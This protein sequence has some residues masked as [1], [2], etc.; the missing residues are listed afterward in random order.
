M[1]TD[2][3]CVAYSTDN[4][5]AKYLGISLF[6]LLEKNKGFD[7]IRIAVLDCGITSENQANLNQIANQYGREIEYYTLN[8]AQ[9]KLSVSEDSIRK[10]SIAS[11]SRL[12]LSSLLDYDR[13]LY[14]DCDT[15][16]ASDLV[17][18]WNTDMGD[19]LI[20]G[21]EDT[22]DSFFKKVIGLQPN[23]K[24][25]NAGVL[26]INLSAWRKENLEERFIAFIKKFGGS[27]PHHDQGTLNGVCSP[28][29]TVLPVRNNVTSNIY[30]FPAR[31]IKKMYQLKTYYSQEEIN[32]ALNHPAIVHFTSGLMGR[33]WEE[34]CN[35]PA[36]EL[37]LEAK[38]K[39]IWRD[40]PLLPDSM[41]KG[42]RLF[43]HF[44]RIA[45]LPLFE[46]S[47]RLISW[48]I[49]TLQNAGCIGR[50]LK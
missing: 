16:V 1:K 25:V 39:T 10:I 50:R 23:S 22:V 6:S 19:N 43:A 48:G 31:T 34:K 38:S 24:Y 15:I 41:K 36:R 5:Y 35:H 49:H 8:D 18:V 30:S 32:L 20:A 4:N 47:Y 44:Y 11:Y 17:D 33:P 7:R 3:L 26:L 42:T 46:A 21:V 29:V 37:F 40:I 2:E 14:I 12:F 28:K 13:V 27:V 9:E 45:P